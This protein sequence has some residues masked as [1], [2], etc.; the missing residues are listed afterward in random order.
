MIDLSTFLRTNRTTSPTHHWP[1]VVQC[2]R[3]EDRATPATFT[4]TTTSVAVS[5]T[6]GVFS[7][8]EAIHAAN[9]AGPGPHSIVFDRTAMG[10][11]LL[12]PAIITLVEPLERINV[13]LD[14]KDKVNVGLTIDGANL[15]HIY[16]Y[17]APLGDPPALKFRLFEVA[18]NVT[19]TLKGLS[20]FKGNVDGDGGAILNNG[21]LN[22]NSSTVQGNTAGGNGGGI[23]NYGILTLD[24]TFVDQNKAGGKGG[25]IADDD[26][27]VCKVT[28]NGSS[29]RQNEAGGNG[30]GFYLGRDSEFAIS[31]G[32]VNLNK[33][34]GWGGGLYLNPSLVQRITVAQIEISGN[35][36]TGANGRGGGIYAAG[37]A[38]G[39]TITD[40]SIRQNKASYGAGLFTQIRTQVLGGTFE[41]NTATTAGGAIYGGKADLTLG[42]YAFNLLGKPQSTDALIRN[43]DAPAG[44]GDGIAWEKNAGG[45]LVNKATMENDTVDE[46]D[47]LDS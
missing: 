21:T 7:L 33:T 35:E 16:R 15:T 10:L 38:L 28:M 5:A 34:A 43:N 45:T 23:M 13:P 30:G 39:V 18:P 31:G 8:P 27:I 41:S 20:L 9:N 40:S 6:D 26:D 44:K 32:S 42:P 19:V 12:E 36:T 3:L 46:V 22:L 4:V 47:K 11:G 29:L 17:E 25:G 14:P 2:E 1:C 24:N 37:S